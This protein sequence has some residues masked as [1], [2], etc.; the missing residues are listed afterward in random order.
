ME[1]AF[2]T[3]AEKSGHGDFGPRGYP[4]SPD[5]ISEPKN[6]GI[7]VSDDFQDL[8]FYKF[9]IRSLPSAV[10]TINADMEITGFNLSA[11]KVTG[12]SSNEALGRHCDEIL[13][14]G[15]CH[16]QCPL[17]TVLEGHKPMSLAETTIQNKSGET[18]PVRM[19][20]AGLFDDDGQLIGG[21]ESF[22]DISKLKTL[23]REKDNLISMFGHDMKS[24][25][26]T[27]GG[28]V[29]RLLKKGKKID[30]VAQKKHLEVIKNESGRLEVLIN[31]L[32]EFSHLQTGRLKLHF[33]PTSIDKELMELLDTYQ[34]RASQSGVILQ[35]QNEEALPI[36]E[37]DLTQLH[38]VFVNLLDNALK[39]SKE[40]G[41]ITI[42]AQ[43]TDQDILV[44][45][46]D[47]GTGIDPGDMPYIFEAFHRGKV[48][49]KVE[50]FGLGLASVKTIVEGH[51]GQVRVE[52]ELGQ[53]AV[54]T[55][56]LPKIGKYEL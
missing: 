16:I 9:V 45:V 41:K 28:F 23:E 27:I 17:R 33:C 24:S 46:S 3:N 52:S 32:L 7:D 6:I 21:V 10:V 35:L 38:R 13:Q 31:D 43:D 11:E 5:A 8:N 37:A 20:T 56:I 26:T 22:Q 47:Q 12:Y 50:G 54:F 15:E 53:G 2:K 18:I 44:T 48:G 25:I 36:I 29:L 49:E 39:F 14:G 4:N 19:N 55:V 34:L 1:S 40:G 42:T 51:G 30:A